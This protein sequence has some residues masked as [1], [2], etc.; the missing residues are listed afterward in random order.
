MNATVAPERICY[1]EEDMSYQTSHDG[2][3]RG[4]DIGLKRT[5]S[6]FVFQ[7]IL[8]EGRNWTEFI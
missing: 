7:R 2:L 6:L 5:I 3:P 1:S 8:K 4:G